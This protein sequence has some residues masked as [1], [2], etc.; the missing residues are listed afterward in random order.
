MLSARA[1]GKVIITGGGVEAVL[2]EEAVLVLLAAAEA[3]AVGLPGEEVLEV[4]A[5]EEA[6]NAQHSCKAM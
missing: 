6:G 2:A 4:A 1:A 3:A 5:R